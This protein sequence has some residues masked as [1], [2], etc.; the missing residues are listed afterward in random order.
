MYIRKKQTRQKGTIQE[1]KW[2]MAPIMSTEPF[3]KPIQSQI[4][5][6]VDGIKP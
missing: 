2:Q 5:L 1:E 6:G 3:Y 4:K